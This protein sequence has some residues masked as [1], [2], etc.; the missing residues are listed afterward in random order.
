MDFGLRNKTALIT[1]GSKGIGKAIAL[2][3]ASEG[4]KVIICARHYD[5]LRYALNRLKDVGEAYYTA[6]DLSTE[7]GI[8]HI[9]N[10]V[11]AMGGIDILINNVG[12]GG[13]WCDSDWKL[14]F[15]KNV[16]PMIELIKAFVPGMMKK[17]WGRVVTISSMFGKEAGGTLGFNMSKAAQIS[18]MKTYSR[19]TEYIRNNITFNTVAPGYIRVRSDEHRTDIVP[20]RMGLPEEV[21]SLVTFLCSE[22]ASYINGACISVDGGE[23]RSF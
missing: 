22:Q 11:I 14:V 12:G 20:G 6:C 15:D 4:C 16:T 19:Q 9:I 17:G 5:F 23:S 7:E 21:A 2:S 10:V 8:E 1:G 3:L 13:R 18:Y